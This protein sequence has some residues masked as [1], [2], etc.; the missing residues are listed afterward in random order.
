MVHPELKNCNENLLFCIKFPIF[1]SLISN[2]ITLIY[3]AKAYTQKIVRNNY[4]TTYDDG[5]NLNNQLLLTFPQNNTFNN[6]EFIS[7]TPRSYIVI[8]LT[9]KIRAYSCSFFSQIK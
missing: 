4:F 7:S 1:P 6:T 3:E 5:D 9:K 2:Y 8:T